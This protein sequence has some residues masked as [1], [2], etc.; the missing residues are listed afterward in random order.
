MKISHC[1]IPSSIIISCI[2]LSWRYVWSCMDGQESY[3]SHLT[4]FRYPSNSFVNILISWKGD[5]KYANNFYINI[6]KFFQS[7]KWYR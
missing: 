1:E 5:D 6:T 2:N 4:L 3:I 7:D